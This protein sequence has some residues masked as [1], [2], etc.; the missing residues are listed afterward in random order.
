MT[1]ASEP[2]REVLT[3]WSVKAAEISVLQDHSNG[4]IHW[5]IE[6]ATEP[7][8]LRRYRPESS[9]AEINYEFAVLKHLASRGWPVAAPVEDL[10]WYD[11]MAYALFPFLTGT[12]KPSSPE[13]RRDLGRLLG[14]LHHDLADTAGLGQKPGWW[15]TVDEDLAGILQRWH[16][17]AIAVRTDADPDLAAALTAFI[18]P[19]CERL[20]DSGIELTPTFVIHADLIPQN[21]HYDEQGRLSAVLDLDMA[22]LNRR[23]VDVACGRLGWH[24]EFVYG[25]TEITPLSEGELGALDDLFRA[26]NMSWALAVL[27][28]R[29]DATAPNTTNDELR[30]WVTALEQTRPFMPERR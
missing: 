19:V 5:R 7:V 22:H 9:V 15:K 30:Q 13:H 26:R 25:Y 21:V 27:E 14:R 1:R 28:G 11:G 4:N 18:D 2:L 10:C 17:G 29:G 12:P 3:Q 23:A 16:S 6:T 8:V 20:A 24:D